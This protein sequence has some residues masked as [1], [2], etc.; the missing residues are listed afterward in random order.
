MKRITPNLVSLALTGSIAL[1]TAASAADDVVIVYDGSGS[2]WGQIDGS[3]K[4]EIAREVLAD[5]VQDWDEE[6][7]LGLVAYGHRSQGDCTDIETILLPAPLNRSSFIEAVNAIMPVG[8]TPITA[9]VQHAADLLSYRDNP[10]T[11]IL[12]SDG[13]ET[14]NADPCALSAQLAQQGV[15]FTAHVV[16]FDLDDAAQASLSCIAENTGGMFVPA[17]NADELHYALDQVQSAMD[18]QPAMPD[19]A[20][21]EPIA[22]VVTVTAPAQATIGAV[23]DV[24]W[25]KTVNAK[26]YI[27]IV[28]A[29]ADEGARQNHIRARDDLSGNLTAPATPGLYEVRYVLEQGDKTIG[30]AS[31]EV[32][33]AGVTITAPAQMTTGAV[34]DVSWDKTVNATDYITIVPAGSDEGTRQNHI[35]ARDN[36][37]GMLTAPA[38][39]GLYEV[40]YVLAE[41]NKTLGT[42][43]VELVETGV[44]VTA[45]AQMTTGA[46]FDVSW[47]K[48]V[49]ATDYITIVPAGSDE[50]TRQNHIRARDNL[51]G[52]LTAPATPG[53]YE[54]RYVLAEGN[55]TLGTATVELV[56]TGVTV[57]APAQMTT[58]SV[59]DVSW[60]KT[61]NATDYITIVPAGSDEGTRQNHIRARDNLSGKLT[62]PATPGLYEVRYVLAEG[63]K[64]LGMATIEL[65]EPEMGISGPGVVRAGT[66]VDIV[67]SSVINAVDYVTI[68][69]AGAEEGARQ[70]H[71]RVRDK[72]EGRLKAPEEIGLYEIRYVLEEGKR[73]LASASLEVVAADAPLDDGAGLSAPETAAAGETITVTWT[74]GGDGADQRIAVARKDQPDFSWISTQKITEA[75]NVAVKMPDES[76]LYEVRYLDVSNRKLLGRSV[77][78]VK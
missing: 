14:C 12:I 51:S 21:E 48:T 71:L 54:V 10:A 24:S 77:V 60:D 34:F 76:G 63:N 75:Q 62:A 55:K 26:D 30:M 46:V 35:R 11:V 52:M 57:T 27:T 42:A 64:T 66:Q 59:F 20:P 3:S 2:M 33:E 31:V 15:K 8:K 41:G 56:E 49:N 78:E 38:T 65:V 67:W 5:L 73:M 37:S 19:P 28:P 9:S 74:G 1:A 4:V 58:G 18:L 44:T 32:V 70:T 45:P 72:T 50:G 53:L 16:G 6:T 29:G 13:V 25:D 43:T 23:F 68:V 69:P 22:P 61:V 17:G 40:R 47:D 36:L 39:P 7:N